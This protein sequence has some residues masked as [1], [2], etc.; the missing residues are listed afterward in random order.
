MAEI[1]AIIVAAGS[2]SRF[3][4]ALPKQ[5]CR[6]M[7]RPVVMTA[8]DRIRQAVPGVD[9]R[10]V[11]SEAFMDLWQAMCRE[12]GFASPQT[13]AG[14]D[15]RWASVRNAL[16]TIPHSGG[17]AV[18][19]VHDAARPL[20]TRHVADRLL[21]ALADGHD[22]AV[23]CVAVV[24]SIRHLRPDGS[25]VAVARSDYRCVQT[26]QAFML[27]DLRRA[28]AM[29]YSPEM[30]DDASVMEAAGMKDIALVDGDDVLMKITRPGDLECVER[31]LAAG[32]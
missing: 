26:P 18:V 4:S 10:L 27:E 28:Y 22:G 5:F 8:I 12:A 14:G 30:T 13:V 24:D 7:G 16:E 15:S 6:L 32:I 31:Y 20:I 25:S 19:M 21:E 2:G 11:L 29:G 3:G 23:P 9:V 17:D 1:Y